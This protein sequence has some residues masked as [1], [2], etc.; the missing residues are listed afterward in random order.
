[1]YTKDPSKYF[2]A[3][4]M[5]YLSSRTD[6]FP[7]AVLEAIDNFAVPIVFDKSGGA[8]DALF[9]CKKLIIPYRDTNIAAKTIDNFTNN[10][11][12]LKDVAMKGK[13]Y[14]RKYSMDSYVD[15]LITALKKA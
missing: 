9:Y 5:F 11:K 10:K 6:S 13:K 3:S 15:K 7:S 4:D 12:Q 2:E 8:P 14:I 1:D